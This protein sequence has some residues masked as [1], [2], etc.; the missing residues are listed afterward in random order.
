MISSPGWVCLTNGASGPMSTR[1]WTTSRPGTLRS[2]CWRSVR[3]SPGACW[4]AMTIPPS[5]AQGSER[6]PQLLREQLRLFPG[7]EVAAPVDLVEV[8]EAG[9]DLL[10]PAARRLDELVGEHRVSH[11][12]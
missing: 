2:C 6:C 11:R 8:G 10:G 4:T 1:A 3:H 5:L 9:V 12:E 7:G